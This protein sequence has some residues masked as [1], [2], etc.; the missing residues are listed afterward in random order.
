MNQTKRC[1]NQLP[2]G[3]KDSFAQFFGYPFRIK[4]QKGYDEC[5]NFSYLC[6]YI[7][8]KFLSLWANFLLL[9]ILSFNYVI[10]EDWGDS[11]IE[12]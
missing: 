7:I 1:R 6:L 3:F 10:T 8:N 12:N 5:S 11:D 4:P 2:K 9:L